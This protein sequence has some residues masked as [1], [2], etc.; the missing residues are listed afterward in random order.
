MECGHASPLQIYLLAQAAAPQGWLDRASIE[1]VSCED[2]Q[3]VDQ[4]WVKYSNGHFG[5]SVQQRI[6]EN[7]RESSEDDI[8]PAMKNTMSS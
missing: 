1:E 5:F 6:Y 7:V 3:T 8:E 2:L 4:L